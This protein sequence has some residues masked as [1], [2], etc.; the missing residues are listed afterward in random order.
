MG[1]LALHQPELIG[2]NEDL[3]KLKQAFE[4]AIAGKGS[5]IFIAGE[6]GIGKTRLVSELMKEAETKN[7]QIITGRCLLESL[8]PLMP[9]KSALRE[10]G[11][12]HLIS[13]DPPPLVVSA[14]MTNDAGLLLAKA[15]REQLG[16]DPD[17]FAGMLK[18][19]G[20]FVKDS[21]H[22]ID[23]V[24]RTGGINILGYQEYKII[25]EESAGI[26]L[27]A[28]TKGS[29]S[30]FLVGDMKNILA[31]VQMSHGHMLK[32]WDGDLDKVKGIRPLV[33]KLITAGKYDGKFLVDDP[34]I[35]Q[36]NVFDNVLMGIQ[37]LSADRS[38]LLFLDDLHWADPSTLGLLHYLARNT[39]SDKVLIVGDYR[40]EDIVQQ[41]DG[42]AHQLE[43]A[44]QNM[45]REDLLEK[46]ELDR[47][48][49]KGTEDLVRTTLGTVNF[50]NELYDR[51]FRETEGTPFFVLEV[52]KLLAE[53]GWIKQDKK[54][55]WN[56]TAG[57]EKM[58][59]PS[60]V[61]DVIKRRLDRLM[62]E[63]KKILDCAS[64]VGEEFQS[65][66]VG[67][68]VGLNKIQLLENLSDVEKTHRLIHS[69]QKKY[70]FDHAKIREVLYNGIMD[71]LKQEYHKL[72]A[73]T[74]AEL[75]RDNPDEA[76]NALAH[77]YYEAKDAKAAE[78]LIKSADAAMGAYANDEA[79][80]Y[81]H[82]ALTGLEDDE[83]IKI[84][85]E[86]LGDIYSL[87]SD[88][89]NALKCYY[90]LIEKE[91]DGR[92]K[93][94]LHR[95][96][97]DLQNKFSK[98]AESITEC[99]KALAILGE[100]RCIERARLL[101]VKA[102]AEML[103][104]KTHNC[105]EH[106]N[107]ALGIA[108]ELNDM[109][110]MASAYHNIGVTFEEK[111]DKEGLEKEIEYLS[112][113]LELREKI[114]NLYDISETLWLLAIAHRNYGEIYSSD[115][116]H[117]IAE[118]KEYLNR[119]LEIKNRIGDKN[120]IINL[121]W[122]FS[123]YETNIEKSLKYAYES[124][125]IAQSIGDHNFEVRIL[126]VIAS[127]QLA[128]GEY[129]EAMKCYDRSFE[130]SQKNSEDNVQA[131]ILFSKGFA[132]YRHG[133]YDDAMELYR[134]SLALAEKDSTS[135]LYG[136]ITNAMG[137][138]YQHKKEFSSALECYNQ[139]RKRAE[140]ID[141]LWLKIDTHDSFANLYL[142]EGKYQEAL[143]EALKTI[144]V[145]DKL[146]Q[147][148]I[149]FK[150]ILIMT[151]GKVHRAMK[152]WDSA[153]QSFEL[154]KENLENS[155]NKRPNG[156]K[157][158]LGQFYY[159]YALLWKDMGEPDKLKEYREKALECFGRLNNEF[160]IE[161]CKKALGDN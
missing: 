78:Y 117:H 64:V 49:R 87:T 85:N 58:D 113:S 147:K 81:Y 161:K 3:N 101:N 18:G 131:R 154:A 4:N 88:F 59:I 128:K 43:T 75:H 107:E 105:R 51:I 73:D 69:Y 158:W 79:I 13:G 32:E 44:M 112:K 152:N 137:K 109:A 16:L 27:A 48:D 40:P 39:R 42:K 135:Y 23:N 100:E 46:I 92:K 15:E 1:E 121:L 57:L 54:G 30:E 110:E 8:E 28:V 5:T 157:F 36:E 144:E 114:G 151:L 22:K 103:T 6:A 80:R 132:M 67:K 17:I 50:E 72:V 104:N 159:E 145:C 20:N 34:R 14:Y 29:L 82:K 93:A 65:D 96:I 118:S 140:E 77:H 146:T 11:L 89:D 83:K 99:D 119:G 74:I 115:E 148:E 38:L 86:R 26:F 21:M 150:G 19:V 56:A 12:F 31:E 156:P 142:D 94:D 102:W 2:R 47:L 45:T 122:L 149:M 127:S 123:E 37:R 141:V 66:V 41:S 68:V 25:V 52:V 9:V 124:L 134:N 7:A 111:F 71:E 76:L 61:Y 91:T 126:G 97:A 62:K 129:D 98:F 153:M 155:F 10:A 120:G 63:Q 133:K 138:I 106:A 35:R 116:E 95:K 84:V 125:R 55:V 136:E 70:K 90:S 130:I 160:W 139:Q 143:A 24:D 33:S 108:E 60:K 53:E